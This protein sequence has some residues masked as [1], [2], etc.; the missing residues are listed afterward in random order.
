MRRLKL[1]PQMRPSPRSKRSVLNGIRSSA[2]Q[3]SA[4]TRV[5]TVHTASQLVLTS[6]PSLAICAS[7]LAPHGVG[8]ETRTRCADPRTCRGSPRTES[9]SPAV[10][11]LRMSLTI[12]PASHR[13]RDRRRRCTARR[14]R[15]RCALR[16]LRWPARLRAVRPARI[17]SA[18]SPARH[19]LFVERAVERD[20]RAR[21]GGRHDAAA[22]RRLQ[23]ERRSAAPCAPART[24]A[25]TQKASDRQ[26]KSPG[27]QP[28]W[29]PKNEFV[30]HREPQRAPPRR[31]VPIIAPQSRP[32][33]SPIAVGR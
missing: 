17:R 5:A 22:V 14:G 15:T 7:D 26:N 4:P 33:D 20:R 6:R 10:K 25:A 9:C 29:K 2:D 30:I 23:R 24:P 11:S 13:S 27:Q 21:F 32:T 3:P 12:S 28:G 19:D 16:S 31:V 18:G 8:R 1:T